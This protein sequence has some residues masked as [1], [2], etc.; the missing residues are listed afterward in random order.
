MDDAAEFRGCEPGGMGGGDEVRTAAAEGLAGHAADRLEVS[1]TGED[2][3]QVPHDDIPTLRHDVPC[4]TAQQPAETEG[5]WSGQQARQ[6]LDERV[7]HALDTPLQGFRGFSGAAAQGPL[8]NGFP[9]P[10]QGRCPW[11]RGLPF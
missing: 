7:P 10:M 8:G 3:A 11:R 5:P 9:R 4:Q 6:P 2:D 1:L